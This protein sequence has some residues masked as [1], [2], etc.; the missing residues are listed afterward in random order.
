MLDW[1]EAKLGEVEAEQYV[2]MGRLRGR[3]TDFISCINENKYPAWREEFILEDQ[4]RIH[5]LNAMAE[6]LN[7]AIAECK[8][9]EKEA[10]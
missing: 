8:R 5:E 6:I 3:L 9:R 10:K 1:L 2:M 4:R 7:Q